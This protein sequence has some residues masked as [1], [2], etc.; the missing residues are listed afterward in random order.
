MGAEE[1]AC[2][3]GDGDDRNDQA[4][5]RG[6]EKAQEHQR[7]R[8]HRHP[9]APVP[10]AQP[11]EPGR[12]RT[13]QQIDQEDRARE[14]LGQIE[15][16]IDQPVAEVIV[17]RHEAAHQQEGDKEQ[18]NQSGV[19]QVRPERGPEMAERDADFRLETPR[20]R[21]EPDE[22]SRRRD[23]EGAHD[24]QR[25][26]PGL[27]EIDQDAGEDAPEHTAIGVAG[28]VET[29]GRPEVSWI[30]LFREIGHRHRRHAG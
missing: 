8:C 14:G 24:R 30:H 25:D 22:Q 6:E 27:R 10:T 16:R 19:A 18:L 12:S 5:R 28:D 29:H 23:S 20:C 17:G 4:R 7:H 3:R 13:A 21:Q 2:Q 11:A 1:P 9:P 15:R 26:T